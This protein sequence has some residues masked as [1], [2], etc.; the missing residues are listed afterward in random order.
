MIEKCKK[1]PNKKVKAS[2]IFLGA[3][4][5][6]LAID[7]FA[8]APSA[9]IRA[10]KEQII[11]YASRNSAYLGMAGAG[12]AGTVMAFGAEV[13]KVIGNNLG[14]VGYVAFI[15]TAITGALGVLGITI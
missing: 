7:A 13:K 1:E 4:L 15:G 9:E 11:D 3:T 12:L 2:K 10:V 8:I 14:Y 6:C 5:C